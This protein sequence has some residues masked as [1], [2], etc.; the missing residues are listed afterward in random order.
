MDEEECMT[1]YILIVAAIILL[2]LFLN[3]ISAKLGIPVLLALF[4]SACCLEQM[5]F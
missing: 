5:V 3:K 2:C 4:C 1:N